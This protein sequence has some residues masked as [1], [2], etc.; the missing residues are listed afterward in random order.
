[1]KRKAEILEIRDR[2]VIFRAYIDDVEPEYV[3]ILMVRSRWEG[4]WDRATQLEIEINHIDHVRA[5]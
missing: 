4:D 3:D 2:K 1:M 5:R